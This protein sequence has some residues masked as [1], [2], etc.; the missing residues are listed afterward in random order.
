MVAERPGAHGTDRAKPREKPQQ[1]ADQLRRLIVSGEL[2]DG[3]SLG[4]EHD[5]VDRFAVS[6]P[7]LR[8]ALRILE[9]EGLITVKRG[10]LGGIVV[11]QPGPRMTARTAALLLQAR[12]VPLAD[13]YEARSMIEPVAARL[14]AQSRSRRSAATEP[15][16][17]TAEQLEVIDDPEA[18]GRANSASA[19]ASSSCPGTRRW[20]SSRRC[21]PRSSP[22]PSPRCAS[23]TKAGTRPRPARAGCG[24]RP[25][26]RRSWR[27]AM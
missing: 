27:P 7:S 5:L 20:R 16:R 17:L 19:P 6:H 4:R 24:P 11:H 18:F 10:V 12:N 1:I 13:V 9:A 21:S 26:S 14:A 3:E 23:R 15:R 22:V 25:G 2:A 8:E